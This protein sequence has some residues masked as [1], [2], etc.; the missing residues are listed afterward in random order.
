MKIVIHVKGIKGSSAIEVGELA[1]AMFGVVLEVNGTVIDRVEKVEPKFAAD[2]ATVEVT[3]LP[4]EIEVLTHGDK[5]WDELISRADKD[6][7]EARTGDDRLIARN[8]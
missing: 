7:I 3:M 2:F 6:R 5:S 4:G 8:G 1:E